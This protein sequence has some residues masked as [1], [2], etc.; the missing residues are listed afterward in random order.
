MSR[1]P[2]VWFVCLALIFIAVPIAVWAFRVETADIKGRGDAE[3][4]IQAAPYRMTK[5]N[6]FFDLCVSVQNAEASI[7]TL[8]SQLNN[9]TDEG[10]RFIVRQ[11]LNG[12]LAARANGINMYNAEARK[13]TAEEFRDSDLPE[14]LSTQPYVVGGIK[15]TCTA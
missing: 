5:Y 2:F 12:A 10:Q 7:D 8:T 6:Y 13:Y 11:N 3:M 1:S 4:T 15:T 9:T 14:Q